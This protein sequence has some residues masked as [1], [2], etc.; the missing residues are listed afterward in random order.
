MKKIRLGLVGCGNMMSNHM[1]GVKLVENALVT[2]ICDI[3]LE[4]A[5]KVAGVLDNPY[6]TT[7]YHTMVDYVVF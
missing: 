1:K 7:D 6:V 2:A 5:Q 3:V 4:N